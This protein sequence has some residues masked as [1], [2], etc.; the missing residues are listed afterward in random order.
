MTHTGFIS[1]TD[2]WVCY[3]CVAELEANTAEQTENLPLVVATNSDSKVD[4]NHKPLI[5]Q[6]V[7]DLSICAMCNIHCTISKSRMHNLQISD[8]NL[9]LTLTQTIALS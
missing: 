4:G 1:D 6:V 9:T 3:R 5:I 2:K 8:L 7:H